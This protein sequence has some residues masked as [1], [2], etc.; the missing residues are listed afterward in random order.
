MQNCDYPLDFLINRFD[1]IHI[2]SIW[3]LDSEIRNNKEQLEPP[4][5]QKF[6]RDICSYQSL[7]IFNSLNCVDV[8]YWELSP[9]SELTLLQTSITDETR[10][11]FP[12]YQSQKHF[13]RNLAANYLHNS[14]TR[15]VR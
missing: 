5:L 14:S 11:K 15:V 4:T 1:C 12:K 2:L 10:G 13:L 6:S 7:M 3:I 8:K 9:N